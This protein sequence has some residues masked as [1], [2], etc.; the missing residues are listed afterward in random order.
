MLGGAQPCQLG[1]ASPLAGDPFGISHI[2]CMIS[3]V[4]NKV[5]DS[6]LASLV[7]SGGDT[8]SGCSQE[9]S[10]QLFS[11]SSNPRLAEDLNPSS[12]ITLPP[13]SQTFPDLLRRAD[14]RV[15]IHLTAKSSATLLNYHRPALLGAL[16]AK[17]IE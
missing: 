10:Q 14:L 1:S 7:L 17:L 11:Q 12:A 16:P 15:M 5:H 2:Q 3:A 4:K 6:G 13:C 9:N 8:A